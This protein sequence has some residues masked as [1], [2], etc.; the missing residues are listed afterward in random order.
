MKGNR[1]GWPDILDLPLLIWHEWK[2]I[3]VDFRFNRCQLSGGINVRQWNTEGLPQAHH[4]IVTRQVCFGHEAFD[5]GL[6]KHHTAGYGL[7]TAIK[8]SL[9]R[10]CYH[11]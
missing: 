3:I 10:L 8:P 5:V 6:Q 9:A 1:A 4:L 11:T 7:G 2:G